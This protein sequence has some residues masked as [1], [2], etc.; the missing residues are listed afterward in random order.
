MQREAFLSAKFH[1]HGSIKVHTQHTY[2]HASIE[3]AEEEG[4]RKKKNIPRT[5]EI[6][7]KRSYSMI[8]HAVLAV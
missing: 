2:T 7:I 5:N 1:T 3:T 8:K 6:I 4:A